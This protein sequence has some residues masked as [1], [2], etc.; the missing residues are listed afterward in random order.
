[1]ITP[2]YIYC[3]RRHWSSGPPG[4]RASDDDASSEAARLTKRIGVIFLEGLRERLDGAISASF[5]VCAAAL[6]LNPA[7]SAQNPPAYPDPRIKAALAEISAAQ[8]QS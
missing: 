1:M 5:R 4:W 8:I 2:C 3:L 6:F 7:M